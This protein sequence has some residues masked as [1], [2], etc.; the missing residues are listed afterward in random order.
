MVKQQWKISM[1]TNTKLWGCHSKM[2]ISNHR[3]RERMVSLHPAL[4]RWIT[5]AAHGR[6][7]CR[8]GYVNNVRISQLTVWGKKNGNCVHWQ[9]WPDKL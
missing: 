4:D 1:E 6:I 8:P 5:N 3:Y 7:R 2:S 9:L